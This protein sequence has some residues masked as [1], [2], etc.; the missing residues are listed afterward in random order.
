[1]GLVRNTFV[2][3]CAGLGIVVTSQVPEF[4]Q[5][6]RQRLGGAVAELK[7]VVEDFDKDAERSNMQRSQ[8]LTIMKDSQDAFTRERGNSMT[9]TIT[10]FETLTAQRQSMEQ[11]FA[12]LRP[13]HMLQ[14]PDSKIIN[15]AWQDFETAIP[16][17]L[18]GF[19]WGGLGFVLMG[20]AGAFIARIVAGK[21]EEEP[22]DAPLPKAV[23]SNMWAPPIQYD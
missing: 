12:I 6:Y 22:L 19:I 13:W 7:V 2:L 21:N 14:D 16:L 5:Q 4:A 1:M 9:K 10:R 11:S 15:E 18:P 23:K 20:A 8:A 17:T 3:A